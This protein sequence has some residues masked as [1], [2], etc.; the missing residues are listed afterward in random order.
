MAKTVDQALWYPS[1]MLEE[2]KA[3]AASLGTTPAWVLEQSW[4]LARPEVHKLEGNRSWRAERLFAK[5]YGESDK[6]KHV[7]TLSTSTMDEIKTQSARLDRSMSWLVARC[8]CVARDDISQA[9]S[10]MT[11][12]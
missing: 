9:K 10:A 6:V 2:M 12:A 8:F 5:R 7:L 3:I 11:G 4:A 1:S